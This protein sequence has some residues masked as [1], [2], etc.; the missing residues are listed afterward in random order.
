MRMKNLGFNGIQVCRSNCNTKKPFLVS[1]KVKFQFILCSIE[2]LVVGFQVMRKEVATR[3][4]KKIH[5]FL[6]SGKEDCL[7]LLDLSDFL[8]RGNFPGILLGSALGMP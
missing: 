7:F 4:E 2:G 8:P 5:S 1:R 3:F 6:G